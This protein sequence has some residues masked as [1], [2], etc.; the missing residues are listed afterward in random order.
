M[1]DDLFADGTTIPG[2][3]THAAG[4]RIVTAQPLVVGRR[5]SREQIIEWLRGLGFVPVGAKDLL[6]RQGAPRVL[7]CPSRKRSPNSLRPAF[8]IDIIPV[9]ADREMTAFM[10]SRMKR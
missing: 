5:P 4:P 10:R 8:P 9:K 3:I 7:R 1:V 6:A 2:V